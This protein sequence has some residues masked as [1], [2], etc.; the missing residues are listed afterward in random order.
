MRLLDFVKPRAGATTKTHATPSSKDLILT[1]L[2]AH[3]WKAALCKPDECLES[4]ERLI[5]R[6]RAKSTLD[7]Y[8]LLQIT[9]VDK[10]VL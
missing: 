7:G 5:E 10:P 4:K 2:T 1:M 6:G 3:R 9:F 8:L